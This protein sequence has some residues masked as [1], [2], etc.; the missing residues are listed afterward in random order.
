VDGACGLAVGVSALALRANLHCA[1]LV[2]LGECAS[3]AHFG[4]SIVTAGV[5]D[6]Q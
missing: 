1:A 4:K 6:A 3:G 5:G 2:R